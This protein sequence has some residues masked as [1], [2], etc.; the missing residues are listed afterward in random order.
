[1]RGFGNASLPRWSASTLPLTV[2]LRDHEL[3][4]PVEA[5]PPV[6]P[7]VPGQK[8]PISATRFYTA[9]A[10]GSILNWRHQ[11]LTDLRHAGVL[12]LDTY[13]ENLTAPLVNEYMRIKTMHLL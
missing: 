12:T 1:M 7:R 13:P 6:D 2:L 10:A 4:D 5:A 9:A 8:L 11:V 3:F